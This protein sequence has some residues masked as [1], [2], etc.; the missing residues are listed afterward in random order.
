[1]A[2]LLWRNLTDAACVIRVSASSDDTVGWKWHGTPHGPHPTAH[3]PGL[4]MRKTSDTS[5]LRDILQ[6]IQPVL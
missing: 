6:N 4:V 3:S 1:M 2:A 5:Q